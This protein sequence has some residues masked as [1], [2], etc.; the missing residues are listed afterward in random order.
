MCQCFTRNVGLAWDTPLLESVY[1]DTHHR[2]EG[3]DQNEFSLELTRSI[4]EIV[5]DMAVL[6]TWMLRQFRSIRVWHIPSNM[7]VSALDVS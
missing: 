2:L 7:Q 4:L 5:R 6:R 1:G 3:C